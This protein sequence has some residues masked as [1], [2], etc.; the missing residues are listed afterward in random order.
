MLDNFVDLIIAVE[1]ATRRSISEDDT[2]IYDD[3][4]LKYLLGIRSLY[5]R[6]LVPNHHLALHLTQCL[7]EF[8]PVHAWWTFPFER[9]N[10]II[11]NL[12]TNS[13][14]GE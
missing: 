7:K 2:T 14:T 4:M 9:Y 13:R 5:D 3:H 11:G 10:G 8:G 1:H 12:K 6:D